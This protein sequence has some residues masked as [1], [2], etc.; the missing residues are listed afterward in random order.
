M[1][2]THCPLCKNKLNFTVAPMRY[3]CTQPDHDFLVICKFDMFKLTVG[4]NKIGKSV[5][6]TNYY[7]NDKSIPAFHVNDTYNVFLAYTN[8]NLKAFL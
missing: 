2:P 5:Q 3:T 8:P 7:F 4:S 6:P 1:I